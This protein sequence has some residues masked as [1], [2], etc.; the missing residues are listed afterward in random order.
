MAG[1]DIDVESTGSMLITLR[2]GHE[3]DVI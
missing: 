3:K 2:S 1:F